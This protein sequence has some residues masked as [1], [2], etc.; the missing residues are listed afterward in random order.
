MSARIE[1]YAPPTGP[2]HGKPSVDTLG[3][4]SLRRRL[5]CIAA[6]PSSVALLGAAGEWTLHVQSVSPGAALLVRVGAV[7]AMVGAGTMSWRLGVRTA[8][9][10]HRERVVRDRA[11]DDAVARLTSVLADAH[12]GVRSTLEAIQRGD[13]PMA[14]GVVSQGVVAGNPLVVVEREVVAFAAAV[15]QAM[16][17]ASTRQEMKA[18]RSISLRMLNLLAKMQKTFNR[19]ESA[20]EDPDL[21]G[22]VWELDHL[23]TR[24]GRLAES[25]SLVGGGAPR[26]SQN[27]SEILDVITR[28][29]SEVEHYRRV[30][31][32]PPPAGQVSGR[33]TRSLVHVLAELIDNAT[34]FS[35]P[36][37]DVIVRATPAPDAGLAIEIEDRGRPIAEADRAELN[38]LLADP[39]SRRGAALL[40]DGRI[41]L[42][43]VAAYASRFGFRVA[44]KRGVGG[45]N[46]VV[47]HIPASHF[48]SPVHEAPAPGP[49]RQPAPTA[50][51]RVPAG[52]AP[53]RPQE[54]PRHVSSRSNGAA[55]PGSRPAG[56]PARLPQRR[57]A[58]P[59]S[60]SSPAPGRL[61]TTPEGG[62]QS[63]DAHQL[64][65]R[66]R[67]RSYMAPGL[68]REVQDVPASPAAGSAP[69][70][71]A[72]FQ[73]GIEQGRSHDRPDPAPPAQ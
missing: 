19:L 70:Q 36:G 64:P 33:L 37:S 11:V 3:V 63:P 49:R 21:L 29:I 27:P 25:S 65:R 8:T 44:I 48:E 31:L 7:A 59:V 46:E 22:V 43:V 55:A 50:A 72:A 39:M 18:L 4:R 42:W 26:T 9:E 41:G 66:D 30:K 53:S 32:A 28:A 67:G 13:R 5:R 68:R 45:G 24:A 40:S 16:V 71:F 61:A 34:N 15:Q 58:R 10:L 23:A 52:S 60:E 35:D 73:R 62:G 17:E 51:A 12:E 56:G 54:D 6:L 1:A 38:S 69:E 14:R 20:T 47:V 57:P 2:R